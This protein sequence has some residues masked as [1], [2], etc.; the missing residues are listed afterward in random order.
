MRLIT[1]LLLLPTVLFSQV[2]TESPGG[3][4]K[5]I[6]KDSAN[7]YALESVTVLVYKKSDSTLLNYQLTNPSGEFNFDKVPLNMPLLI[8]ISFSGY[9]SFSKTIKLDSI[10]TAYNFN[11]IQLAA[12][13]KN[14]DEVVIEAVLPIRMN[15]DTLEINPAAFK[16]DSNA[17]VE[18]M[19]RKVPGVTLWGDGTVTVNGKQV[20]NV[21]VDGKPFFG[22]DPAIATQNLPKNAIEKIQVYSETD[23]NKPI[24]ERTEADSLLTMNIKL[25]ADKK[26]GYFGKGGAGLGTDKRFEIDF[27]LQA[28]N[29][30]TRLGLGGGTNNINKSVDD[31]QSLLGET[32]FRSFNPRNRYVANFGGR[33]VNK[34][35]FLGA[36]VQ[37]SFLETTNNQRVN[38]LNFDVSGRGNINTLFSQS[39]AVTT[40]GSN[41]IYKY[42]NRSSLQDNDTKTMSLGY[43]KRDMDK[44]I[45]IRASATN[46]IGAGT[47][48]GSTIAENESKNLISTSTESSQSKTN[49]NSINLSASFLNK[50]SD[51]RNLKSFSIRY[52]SSYNQNE[53]TRN[54]LTDFESTVNPATN[55]YINRLYNTESSNWS[56]SLNVTYNA[57]KRLLF[58]SNNLW[59]INMRLTNNFNFN[60]SDLTYNVSDFD[61]VG[62]TYI[63][64]K[65]ITNLH[66][67]NRITEEPSLNLS[68][69]FTKRLSNRFYRSF[70]VS[71][72]LGAQFLWERDQ[73][74]FKNR[75]LNRDF[76]FFTPNSNIAYHYQKTNGYNI[77]LGVNHSKNYSIPGLDQ[78]FPII[79]S[80]NV[81]SFNYGNQFLKPSSTNN[82]GF[83]FSYNRGARNKKMDMNFNLNG[84]MGFVKNAVADSST[85]LTDGRKNVYLIN[86]DGRRNWGVFGNMNTSFRM[87]KNVLQLSYN[88]SINNSQSPNYIDD[89]FSVSRIQNLSNSLRVYFSL[90]DIVNF[91]VSQAVS[92]SNSIQSGENLRSF[93]NTNYVSS[94]S[95]NLSYPKHMMLSNTLNYV[96][97]NSTKQSSALWNAY[98]T[99]RF[100]KSKQLEAKF[101]AM[102]ILRQNKNIMIG[103][104]NNT[105]TT[106]VTN[107]LQQFYMLTISYYP[108]QFGGGRGVRRG[109][110]AT[111]RPGGN[112][113]GRPRQ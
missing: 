47:S 2:K 102:D 51:E 35:Y 3:T 42:N 110:S 46:N 67:N 41:S 72:N 30:K 7:D 36:N 65:L 43:N 98:I 75:N 48:E 39:D 105:I 17:V 13:F 113:G 70:T 82:F 101:S 50:D 89:I 109:G 92:M 78:L 55:R 61:S 74:N 45:T 64:N 32:T 96:K 34:T 21:Y 66:S 9:K 31:L 104:S 28:Y 11:T 63:E 71:T 100:L 81:Y 84:S 52:N 91:S 107:G 58:G 22:S 106:T 77:N 94:A 68:K 24:T 69:V 27:G 62:K 90:S 59:N 16:L 99:Y 88:A 53:N 44:D 79:D 103:S 20:T 87:K 95:I 37:H 6:V 40:T 26:R 76:A 73:S 97:N 86:I 25:K 14:L 18:D 5:G 54:T 93:R 19:L 1:I 108:R 33:G 111:G 10:N 56:N 49:S 83:N 112:G 4:V 80:A 29:K 60:Q 57:L 12:G 15:G 38:E 23:R 8:S 85:Y